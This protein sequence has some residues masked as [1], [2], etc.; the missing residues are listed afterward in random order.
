MYLQVTEKII[1]PTQ[2]H[3]SQILSLKTAGMAG[4]RMIYNV[5]TLQI[6]AS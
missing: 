3:T 1:L 4:M 2:T 5:Y 6:I